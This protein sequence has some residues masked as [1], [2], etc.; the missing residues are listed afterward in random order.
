MCGRP[1]A[2]HA[3]ARP[4]RSYWPRRPTTFVGCSQIRSRSCQRVS[5]FF[6]S[7]PFSGFADIALRVFLACFRYLP[8]DSADNPVLPDVTLPPGSEIRLR[9]TTK[10]TEKCLPS[11]ISVGDPRLISKYRGTLVKLAQKYL[12][13]LPKPDTDDRSHEAPPPSPS[14]LRRTVCRTMADE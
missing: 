4:V 3:A 1:L 6:A 14:L 8:A 9:P 2:W 7:D 13:S 5:T 11:L 12:R 10:K